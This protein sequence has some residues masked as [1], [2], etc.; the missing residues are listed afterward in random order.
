MESLQQLF[1][2]IKTFLD[3]PVFSAG[4]S[5]ITLW[6]LVS[7]VILV[8]LLFSITRWLKV[9]IVSRLLAN[10][11]VELG[12]RLA[13]GAIVRYIVIAVGLIVILQTT[14]IDLST[15]T[16]LAGALGV[17]VGFGLQNITNN[18]VSGFL[19]LIERPIKVGDRIEVG[20]VT[21][22]VVNIALRATTVVTNDNIAIIVPNSEFV[23]SRVTNWSYTD[24]NVRFNFPVGVSYRSDPELVRRLLLQVSD[25]HAGVLKDPKPDALLQEFGDSAL[26]FILRVWTKQYATTPGVLRS[27][28]NFM[29]LKTFKEQGIEIPYPQRDLHIRSSDMEGLTAKGSSPQAAS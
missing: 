24:R 11:S 26:N 22:D 2:Q 12:V 25:Q 20:P 6:T 29:I 27:E 1:N 18:F 7:V 28:L 13:V 8:L 10:S 17:G 23:S 15:V 3:I 5:S 4:K 16:I 19:L 14:G 9:W 21:G